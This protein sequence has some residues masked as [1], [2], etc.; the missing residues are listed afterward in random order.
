MLKRNC[1]NFILSEACRLNDDFKKNTET[2]ITLMNASQNLVWLFKAF[3]LFHQ[4]CNIDQESE[5]LNLIL[6]LT[7]DLLDQRETYNTELCYSVA[8]V[9]VLIKSSNFNQSF[10]CVFTEFD[11]ISSIGIKNF[12]V[13]QALLTMIKSDRITEEKC[14]KSFEKILLNCLNNDQDSTNMLAIS[15]VVNHWTLRLNELISIDNKSLKS[16]F[17][18]LNTLS[19]ILNFIWT[20]FDSSI[21]VIRDLTNQTYKNTLQSLNK[22]LGSKELEVLLDNELKKCLSLSWQN[23]A[24]HHGLNLLLDNGVSISKLLS[25]NSKISDE[26]IESINERSSA[27]SIGDLYTKLCGLHK[28]NCDTDEWKFTWWRP[29][30][31]IIESKEKCKQYIYEYLLPRILKKFPNGLSYFESYSKNNSTLVACAKLLRSLNISTTMSNGNLFIGNI[32]AEI[33]EKTIISNDDQI[34]LD[35]FV[36]VCD[37]PKTTELV[38]QVEFDLIRKFLCSNI[39]SLSPSYRQSILASTKKLI[40][41]IEESWS[42][43]LRKL[44]NETIANIKLPYTSFLEWLFQFSFQFIH[45]DGNFGKR[46]LCLS[47]IS[48]LFD[49]FHYQHTLFKC[50]TLLSHKEIF[51][52]I[53]V[54][55]DTYVMNK[56]IALKLLTNLTSEIYYKTGFNLA[57]S[58]FNVALN[59][60]SSRKP[61]DSLTSV[62]LIMLLKEKSKLSDY[63]SNSDNT[64]SLSI[65]LTKSIVNEF[66]KHCN[67]AEK[68]LLMA[69]LN[70]PIYG[71]LSAIRNLVEKSKYEIIEISTKEWKE[72]IENLIDNCLRISNIVGS[73]VSSNSPEGIFPMELRA[74]QPE[75]MAQSEMKLITPQMLLVCCWR[76][77]KE[78][79]LF[80]GY[81]V[82]Q[83]SLEHE[84][85][86]YLISHK[87]VEMIGAYFVKHLLSTRHRGAFE[88]AYMGFCQI[89]EYFWRCKQ[90]IYYELPLKWLDYVIQLM[91]NEESK[92]KIC[93]TRRGGGMPFFVQAIVG[94][95]PNENGYKTLDKTMKILLDLAK[96]SL[97][98]KEN[99]SQVL[100]MYVL[101]ALFKDTRLG[102]EV[103][104]YAEDAIIAAISGFDSVYWNVRNS[105]TILFSSLMNRIF[106]VNRSREEISKKNSMPGKLFFSKFPKLFE[107]FNITI[108][109]T[110]QSIHT[111]LD[112][113]LYLVLL[114]LCRLYTLQD[115]KSDPD[116]LLHNYVPLLI[117]CAQSP[118]MKIR[119]FNAKALST[120]L[121][122]ER[123]PSFIQNLFD[124]FDQ[125]SNDNNYI[126]GLLEIINCFITKLHQTIDIDLILSNLKEYSKS[127]HQCLV[128]YSVLLNIL[129]KSFEFST[130]NQTK[131]KN[132]E[133][134]R[135]TVLNI[136]ENLSNNQA[137]K[138]PGLFECLNY[139][140]HS[141]SL[142]IIHSNNN[143]TKENYEKMLFSLMDSNE[144]YKIDLLN[145]IST[146]LKT[147]CD[148]NFFNQNFT[149]AL[150]ETLLTSIKDCTNNSLMV[151]SLE[152]M[153]VIL[154]N[155][156]L[157][158]FS[159]SLVDIWRIVLKVFPLQ[160]ELDSKVKILN[161]ITVLFPR[162]NKDLISIDS[163]IDLLETYVD[164]NDDL[165]P[166]SEFFRVNLTLFKLHESKNPESYV[167]LWSILMDLLV[168]VDRNEVAIEI[169]A[170]LIDKKDLFDTVSM[171][172][173]AL[174]LFIEQLYSTNPY[175]CIQFLL[176]Q[177]ERTSECDMSCP[178]E[179]EEI[180]VVF[181]KVTDSVSLI[182][183]QYCQ[184]LISKLLDLLN[185]NPSL[186]KT[187]EDLLNTKYSQINERLAHNLRYTFSNLLNEHK[188][189]FNEIKYSFITCNLMFL[190][191]L[192]EFI[193]KENRK[194]HSELGEILDK[195]EPYL[196]CYIYKFIK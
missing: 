178:E 117:R 5:S 56:N 149:L 135:Y 184:E 128:N 147:K 29:I 71:P 102:E 154:D 186:E 89:C 33:L 80:F 61:C 129:I 17:S 158:A 138:V 132:L 137:F 125:V 34:R 146:Y 22:L 156:K 160:T 18:N 63:E 130:N 58:Y 112:S 165:S 109:S 14:Y 157:D 110:L 47:F 187:I 13:Y 98:Q 192:K 83:L 85:N 21:D 185:K 95:E 194:L 169:I 52:L 164:N 32:N 195:H 42:S 55:W 193:N 53:E 162:L 92:D 77:M 116:A 118:I 4:K 122:I 54:L 173:I 174:N 84:S 69:A 19:Q 161:F 50:E 126:N 20:N 172:K 40:N 43:A 170:K 139:F 11:I 76:T 142:L 10:E 93:S 182:T 41:R 100:S 67:L 12:C 171:I 64:I 131:D 124:Q 97:S 121:C 27:C 176:E 183:Y 45:L 79:S 148:R 86:K 166:I 88:L 48:L 25:V 46:N 75:A 189:G 168:D 143:D 68:N 23:Y 159:S 2:P 82:S 6:N 181:D 49:T 70:T 72:L 136:Y 113:K 190:K 120:I 106:G 179:D 153:T 94:T 152:L 73:I 141:I 114:I 66:Q 51:T 3:I 65:F 31:D 90:P 96:D 81:I 127:K 191:E 107:F 24:K 104:K 57:K 91:K 151:Q 175:K 8:M 87:Y 36:L 123:Y 163:L 74:L 39:D 145:G 180:E 37:N 108:H 60:L 44:E 115:E 7:K 99:F 30:V 1:L 196:N 133:I 105:S 144:T 188:T 38:S 16:H 134:L 62:Y 78:I 26:M 101:S 35:S 9:Y 119:V 28:S 155:E 177:F 59:L 150:F 140:G 103:T 15:K 167:R 111:N